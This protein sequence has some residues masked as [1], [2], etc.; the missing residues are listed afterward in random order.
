M[1]TDSISVEFPSCHNQHLVIF[2]GPTGQAEIASGQGL[3]DAK[4][5]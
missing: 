4:S 2:Q 1:L 5:L 3:D